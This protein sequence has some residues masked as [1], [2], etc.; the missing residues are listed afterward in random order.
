MKKISRARLQ[1]SA[2]AF[3]MSI[4]ALTVP[5]QAQAPALEMLG[6]LTKGE[7]VIRSRDGAVARKICLR[8]GDEL[9]QLRHRQPNCN[10]F[11]VED[12]KSEVTVQYTC[13]GNGYGRTNIRRESNILVQLE[14]QGI[15]GGLPFSFT[16]EGRRTGACG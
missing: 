8:R 5:T 3:G 7:W 16:A 11:V 1:F 13:R 6:K 14:S 4:T 12:G 2:I 9:I 10:R 15:E